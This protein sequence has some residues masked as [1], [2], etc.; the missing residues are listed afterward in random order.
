MTRPLEKLRIFLE[1]I[2]FEHS[3]FALPFAYMGLFL[4][5]TERPS[6]RIFFL[7]TAVMVA[8]RS[9]AMGANRILDRTIDAANPRTRSR[10]IPAGLLRV[11]TVVFLTAGF[12]ILYFI[13][14]WVLGG[15]CWMLSPIPFILAWLYPLTKRFTWFSHG[16]LGIILGISPYG[17]WLAVTGQFSWV[18]GFLTLGVAAWVAGFDILY[19]LQDEEFDR[20][21]ALKSWPARFG[22][23]ASLVTARRLHFLACVCWAAAGWLAELGVSYWLGWIL[24]CLFLLREHWLVKSSGLEKIQ[25]AFF[26]MN[27]AVGMILFVS[28]VIERSAWGG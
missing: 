10:A 24:S 5:S 27:A 15:L 17:A 16:V 7:V 18:P 13:S 2:K 12:G 9:M 22:K 4:A 23:A 19:A 8:F 20:S 28:V 1:M 21:A 14:C 6:A 11:R 3:I 26:T 25:E